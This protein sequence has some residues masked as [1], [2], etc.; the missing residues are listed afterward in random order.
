MLDVRSTMGIPIAPPAP[1]MRPVLPA[2][3]ARIV[4]D[5]SELET[6]AMA[7]LADVFQSILG[8]G[9]GAGAERDA[10]SRGHNSSRDATAESN[11]DEV[12]AAASGAEGRGLGRHDLHHWLHA[13]SPA[14]SQ[15]RACCSP[16]TAACNAFRRCCAA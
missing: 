2:P 4:D 13:A 7:W 1:R 9:R 16:M 14:R 10:G 11:Y 15:L 12:S 3:P 6:G 5:S 8:F